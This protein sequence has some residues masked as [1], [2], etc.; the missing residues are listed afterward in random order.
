MGFC[1]YHDNLHDLIQTQYKY[2]WKVN[3]TFFFPK[4]VEIILRLQKQFLINK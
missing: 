4:K 2:C 1:K 3:C